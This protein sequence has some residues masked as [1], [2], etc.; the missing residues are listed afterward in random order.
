[1]WGEE[2]YEKCKHAGA[3]DVPEPDPAN[4]TLDASNEAEGSTEDDEDHG[5]E[6][7]PEHSASS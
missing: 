7:N 1:M 5:S 2:Q 4:V 3:H 6:E